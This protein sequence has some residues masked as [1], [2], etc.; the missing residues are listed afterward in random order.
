MSRKLTVNMGLRYEFEVPR[1]E[2]QDRYSYW[3][4]NA[5]SPIS[6]PG[7][8]LKGVVKFV[9]DKTA[10]PFDINHNNFGPRLG[11]AYALNDKTAIRVGAGKFFLLSRATVSG[12][13][14][15]AF[16]T[17]SAVP[18]S[19]D[20][21]ATRNATLSD[22]Y[23]QGILTPPGRSLGDMTFIGLGVGTITRQTRNPEMYSWNLSIQRDIGWSSMVEIN[24]T[25]SRGVHLYSPY[26]SLSPLAPVYWLGPNAQYTRAQLQAAV[27]NPFYGII[28][29][30]KAVNL[31]GK[32]IQQYRLL[33]NMPQYDGVSGSDPNAADSD[34]HGLQVKYEKRFS[35]G[36]TVLTHYTR[37]RMIDNASVT[38]GNLTWLGGTTSFQN[39]LDLSAERSLSQ[40][41]VAHRFVA[42]GDWQL[43]FGRERRFASGVSR[44]VDAVIGG[45]EVSAFF[46][47]QSGFPLQVAQ[48]GGTLW[49]GTQRPNLIGDAATPGEIHDRLNNYFNQNAFSRPAPDTFG[50]APRTLDI[51]GP[52]VNMLD[53][54]LIK[55]WRT[56]GG[57]RIELRIEAQNARN[58]PVFSDPATSYGA[59]NF[60]VINGTKVGPRNVQLGF[61][62]YF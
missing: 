3:D 20:S 35:R 54:A 61:K 16:N 38:D 29:D 30:P 19:L 24:Y 1:T 62:Y 5:T 22:P 59:S 60:G 50:T 45:W 25:G 58:Y 23:P 10:S 49:N 15:A 2:L 14:G 7:Y 40:H 4:L 13:T 41:D 11:F 36:L 33:R 51:R 27:P 44:L 39:P 32:T 52:R 34:Y 53:A 12:H 9:D 48:S 43:P 21:G 18:W 42:T 47:L 8:N 28:T 37:S 17:D 55:N 31:N 56:K 6:A 26:T 46:T 57:Q